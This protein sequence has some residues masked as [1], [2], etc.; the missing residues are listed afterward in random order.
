MTSLFLSKRVR[1]KPIK[2][3]LRFCENNATNNI[4]VGAP[5]VEAKE[6]TGSESTT[7]GQDQDFGGTKNRIWQRS[8]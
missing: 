5:N 6:R 2:G 1:E 7:S 3:V 8:S 4:P